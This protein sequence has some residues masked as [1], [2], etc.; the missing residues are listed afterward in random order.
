[1]VYLSEEHFEDA[2]AAYLTR[3]LPS[4]LRVSPSYA[5]EAL[6]FP[7]VVV[8]VSR[9]EN[10]SEAGVW[11]DERALAVEVQLLVE[12]PSTSGSKWG[13]PKT[14]GE[15]ETWRRRLLQ[16]LLSADAFDG[17]EA[18]G[19]LTMRNLIVGAITRTA[20]GRTFETTIELSVLAS[21]VEDDMQPVEEETE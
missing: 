4:D 3:E 16:A 2:L 18:Y 14:R 19:G 8:A 13:S 20:V 5:A 17:I 11:S 7:R 1:M 21:P 12:A 6:T 10:S 9:S 15:T